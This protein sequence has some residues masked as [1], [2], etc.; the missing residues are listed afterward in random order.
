MA[1]TQERCAPILRWAGSKRKLVPKIISLFPSEFGRYIEPFAG[2]ACVFTA[3]QPK[4]AI[5]SDINAELIRTYR[6]L[7]ESPEAVAA[8]IQT[9][10]MRKTTY[11]SLRAIDPAGMTDIS[12]AARF[13]YLNRRCFNGVFRLNKQG[14]F[15]VPIGRRTGPMP[16]SEQLARFGELLSRA[17]LR[18]CDFE[19]S[20]DRAKKGD[21]VYVDPPYTRPGTRFRGEYGWNAFQSE[22]E[23]R[24]LNALRR[25]TARGATVILSYRGS[26]AKELPDWKRNHV[27][28]LRS[29]SGFSAK[30]GRVV[31]V[32]FS[33]PRANG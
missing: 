8:E 6:T 27:R 30:R 4:K 23:S 26:I 14:Q 7:A 31:E 5:L 18:T 13:I 2:S 22:D 1:D 20:V 15:N 17:D 9:W 12:S 10:N 29:V 33:S 16:T 11:Y 28:V 25:A 3:L 19:K 24:L 32:L 21:L